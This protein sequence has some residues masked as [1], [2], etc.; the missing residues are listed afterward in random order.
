MRKLIR[1]RPIKDPCDV[2]KL[3]ALIDTYCLEVIKLGVGSEYKS[4]NAWKATHPYRGLSDC[5]IILQTETKLEI[6]TKYLDG[7]PCTYVFDLNGDTKDSVLQGQ[8][9]Y[10]QLQKAFKAPDAKDYHIPALDRWYDESTGKYVCSA[11]PLLG[12]R[13]EHEREE[14]HDCYEYDLNSAYASVL[15]GK[16]PDVNK[17]S[18]HPE[19]AKVRKGEIGFLLD[20]DLTMVREG[21]ADITFPLI[22][23]PDSVKAFCA[24]YYLIKENTSGAAKSQAKAMLNYPIGYYQ[25]KNPFIRSYVVHSCNERIRKLI[26]KD[27]LF[28][29]TDAIFSLRKRDDLELGRGIGKFKEIR[30]GTLKYI[31]NVYQA[32]DDMPK[33]RGI[34]KAYFERFR[35]INGRPFDL[36]KDEITDRR[37]MYSFDFGTLRLEMNYEKTD[38]SSE[39]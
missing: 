27:T 18:Y 22:E 30:L 32:D 4:I 5:M 8:Q 21:Y 13:K 14:L 20:D 39:G 2:E 33:Y 38:Q 28:Y 7:K 35:Q 34:P 10:A 11:K 9:A 16:L 29:N 24:K 12:F 15:S 36:L 1:R 31:G 19:M 3:I 17:P 26:D 23:S 25:R 6:T 37:C